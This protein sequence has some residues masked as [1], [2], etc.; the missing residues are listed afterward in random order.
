MKLIEDET[1]WYQAYLDTPFS[2]PKDRVDAAHQACDP[3]MLLDVP[4]V[5]VRSK[6]REAKSPSFPKHH[7]KLVKYDAEARH[8][9]QVV[10]RG[11]GT[12]VSPR[13]IW[14]G[15]IASYRDMWEVD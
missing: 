10:V 2:I 4:G 5:C 8:V 9:E 14:V 12:P 11:H 15:S 1:Q 6:E 13:A 3:N 7:G